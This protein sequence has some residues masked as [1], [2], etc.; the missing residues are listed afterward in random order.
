MK[1]GEGSVPGLPAAPERSH[2]RARWFCIGLATGVVGTLVVVVVTL[3][4]T[5]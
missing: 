3:S 4:L 5:R 2:G 1:N